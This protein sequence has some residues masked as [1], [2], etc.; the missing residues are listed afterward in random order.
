VSLPVAPGAALDAVRGCLS[1]PETKSVVMLGSENDSLEPGLL[2]HAGPLAAIKIRRVEQPGVL[3]SQPGATAGEGIHAEVREHGELVLLPGQLR[4][5][6][7]GA[8]GRG[9]LRGKSCLERKKRKDA[10]EQRCARDAEW[11]GRIHVAKNEGS[12]GSGHLSK[13]RTVM[14]RHFD[15]W[16]VEQ[17]S[18]F[19]SAD[20]V[21][22]F[23]HDHAIGVC[24]CL[25][26]KGLVTSIPAPLPVCRNH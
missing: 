15:W 23:E 8:Q 17:T 16:R 1:R 2:R 12:G 6:G 7:N 3:G 20:G 21:V 25:F 14:V 9:R 5:R 13:N 26:S 22:S 24:K 11:L 18:Y 10:S 19:A 4:R